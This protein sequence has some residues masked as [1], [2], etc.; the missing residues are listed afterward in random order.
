MNTSE[1]KNNA[2]IEHATIEQKG[3]MIAYGSV[4]WGEFEYD[5]PVHKNFR[6]PYTITLD[7]NVEYIRDKSILPT[8]ER[9]IWTIHLIPHLQSGSSFNITV[10]YNITNFVQYDDVIGQY[11]YSGF[12]GFNSSRYIKNWYIKVKTQFPYP[13]NPQQGS[14]VYV[15][16]IALPTNGTTYDQ[17]M[18]VR[19]IQEDPLIVEFDKDLI[20]DTG[21]L[22][23]LVYFD[24]YPSPR[25][26]LTEK[27]I[28][29]ILEG[30]K[31][32][33]VDDLGPNVHVKY[34]W[35]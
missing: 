32:E 16:Y 12:E 2:T 5:L 22:I 6:R 24:K 7:K 10:K 8:A 28:K 13:R 25:L 17:N 19:V 14:D 4:P 26:E 30:F 35:R 33:Y 21:P 27:D 3:A 20:N 9:P 18:S 23:I 1:V 11:Y 15:P 29:K 31:E 34:Y